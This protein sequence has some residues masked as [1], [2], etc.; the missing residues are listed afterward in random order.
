VRASVSYANYRLGLERLLTL[1]QA[2]GAWHLGLNVLVILTVFGTVFGR[3]AGVPLG[4]T[5]QDSVF[6]SRGLH[7][8]EEREVHAASI[9]RPSPLT[10]RKRRTS[11]MS[12][13]VWRTRG[14]ALAN[15][16]A[17]HFPRAEFLIAARRRAS[18]GD[19]PTNRCSLLRSSCSVG[20]GGWI[21]N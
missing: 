5:E 1:Q 14:Q 4:G 2:A 10:W 17:L 15:S 19:T 20:P 6:I 12:S 9:K 11:Y 21:T 13:Q 7:V 16:A 8:C 3:V 18:K